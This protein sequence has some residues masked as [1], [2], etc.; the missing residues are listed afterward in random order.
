MKRAILSTVLCALLSASFAETLGVNL[1]EKPVTNGFADMGKLSY[2]KKIVTID[3]KSYPNPIDK[4]KA[5]TKAIASGSPATIIV[6]GDIDLSDGKISDD[7]HSYFD[8]FDSGAHKRVHDDI[9]YP[10]S[11]NKTILGKDNAR[12]MFG[13]LSFL[14]GKNLIIRNVTFWDAHGSTEY[15]TETKP[16]SKASADAL[17]IW[18]K[19]SPLPSNIW[20]DHC[21]FTD[22]KCVDMQRNF[23]HD[24]SIDICGGKNITISYCEFTNHDKVLLVASGEKFKEP[25]ERQVTLHHNYFHN[26]TQRLPRSRG[27][28]MH[29]YNNVY[30][31]IGVPNNGG[32][33]FGP[34]TGSMYIVENNYIGSHLA[35]I[36]SYFD[37]SEE[38]D[39]SFSRFYE[40]GNSVKIEEKDVKWDGAEKTGNFKA[41]FVQSKSEIPWKIPYKYELE[42]FEDARQK[43][44]NGEMGANQKIEINN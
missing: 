17:V 26:V 43:A 7:D 13:G 37:K 18:D 22:G 15:S 24:G 27:T 33:M 16:E 11:S 39:K 44:L 34:G 1:S 31:D 35:H 21:T 25:E 12:I 29:I 30:D 9:V 8:K 10:V 38:S 20:I 23:N 2:G 6:S 28:Q 41:H 14:T 40:S 19:K 42:P 3:D 4:R 32:Y 5:F 36:V